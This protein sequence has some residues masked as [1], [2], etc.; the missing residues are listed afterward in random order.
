VTLGIVGER[1]EVRIS[2]SALN[3][4]TAGVLMISVGELVEVGRMSM[5]SNGRVVCEYGRISVTGEA[6][7]LSESWSAALDRSGGLMAG[8]GVAQYTALETVA[9]YTP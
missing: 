4:A 1:L 6:S 2:S 7:D 9:Q 5:L 3:L 8:E